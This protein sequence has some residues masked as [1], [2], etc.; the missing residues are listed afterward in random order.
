MVTALR[1]GRLLSS[2]LLDGSADLLVDTFV[3]SAAGR[4]APFRR[5]LR[6]EIYGYLQAHMALA[7]ATVLLIATWTPDAETEASPIPG[8]EESGRSRSSGSSGANS[9]TPDA[10]T[11]TVSGGTRTSGARNPQLL[12]FAEVVFDVRQRQRFM[13]L[14]PPPGSAYL[15][16][17]A[18]APEARRRGVARQ[19]VTAA[20][21]MC[22]VCG[23]T[24]LYLHLRFQ[25][26]AAGYLYRSTGFTAVEE[27]AWYVT[28]LGMDRRY[29]MLKSLPRE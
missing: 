2:Q 8:M 11:S 19:L 29:L 4:L 14:D 28:L 10:T 25:D 16:N 5:F 17:M 21:A 13:T 23:S 7:P 12:G 24:D 6:R 15:C 22:Q 3:D 9:S 27:D 20:E 26:E 18:V 1:P